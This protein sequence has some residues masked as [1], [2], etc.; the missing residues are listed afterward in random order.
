MNHMR[1][2]EEKAKMRCPDYDDPTKITDETADEYLCEYCGMRK[3]S[4]DGKGNIDA[5]AR[6]RESGNP[7]FI[8]ENYG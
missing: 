1:R 6:G 4:C 5:E 2:Q 3:V 8:G 7:P